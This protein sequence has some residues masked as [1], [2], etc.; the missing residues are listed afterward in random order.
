MNR[1]EKKE[2]VIELS[3]EKLIQHI[4]DGH[5]KRKQL[6]EWFEGSGWFPIEFVRKFGYENFIYRFI[7]CPNTALRWCIKFGHRKRLENVIAHG[8]LPRVAYR[9]AVEFDKP[10]VMCGSI[11]S[12]YYAKRF[13]QD[14]PTYEYQ[15][16][17]HIQTIDGALLWARDIGYAEKAKRIVEKDGMLSDIKDWNKV[18]PD[19]KIESY[20]SGNLM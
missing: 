7:T 3:K 1:I 4:N 17:Q 11:A 16:R 19:H 12:E 15:M 6:C 13:A 5:I 9:Y 18:C 8:G 20:V 10:E 2:Y 14:F